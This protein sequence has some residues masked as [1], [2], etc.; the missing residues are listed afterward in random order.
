NENAAHPNLKLFVY[1]GGLQSSEEAIHYGVP[2]VG[3][4]VLAD[5]DM[6]IMKL[7]SLGVCKSIEILQMT[8]EILN[9][10]IMDVLNNES[11]KENMLKLKNL[12]NDKP[13]DTMEN[14]IWWIEYVIRHKGAHHLRCSIVDEPWYQRYDTDVIA[15]LSVLLL[16]AAVLCLYIAYKVLIIIIKYYL[17]S[18]TNEKDKKVN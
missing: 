6:I 1:Q 5:Q 10:A 16:I 13:V 8:R 3:M 17:T 4:P 18:M 12:I 15:L 7:E 2:L 9:D 11:Y 14:V